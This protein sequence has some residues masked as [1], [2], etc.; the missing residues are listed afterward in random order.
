MDMLNPEQKRMEKLASLHKR[1]GQLRLESQEI[2][3]ELLEVDQEI[4]ALENF[5]VESY[6]V[7]DDELAPFNPDSHEKTKETS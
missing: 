2:T 7:D 6:H 5:D 1:R 4:T 3:K